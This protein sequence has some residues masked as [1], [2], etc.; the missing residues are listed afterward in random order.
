M[1]EFF[2]RLR[3]LGFSLESSVRRMTSM[4]SERFEIKSRGVLRKGAFADV[5]VWSENEFVGRATYG[6]PHEFS[7][8]VDC[9]V[10][11]GTVSYRCGKFTGNRAG[12]MISR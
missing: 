2:R 1:P 3:S 5:V 9:V 11:N 12:R 10:V 7:T 8:G 4:P 6:S